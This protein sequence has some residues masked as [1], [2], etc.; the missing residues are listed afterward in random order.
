[1]SKLFPTKSAEIIREFKGH[2]D[3]DGNWVE[4][5][6]KTIAEVEVDIQ[7]KSGRRRALELQTKYE[8]EYIGFVDFEDIYVTVEALTIFGLTEHEQKVKYEDVYD[9]L[10]ELDIDLIHPGDVL[11]L[12]DSER[13]F[14]IVFPGAW[15][16][17]FELELKEL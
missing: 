6:K 14:N 15:E 16:G 4:G 3:E 10:N 2:N 7:P 8:S 11:D 5:D 1:M 12:I 17:D 13:E 9:D